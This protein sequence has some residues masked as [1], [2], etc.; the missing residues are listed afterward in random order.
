MRRRLL[1]GA[2]VFL[3]LI[4]LFLPGTLHAMGQQEDPIRRAEVLIEENR[5]NEAIRLLERTIR[6]EPER[7]HEAEDL[8][9]EIRRRRGSY[10]ELFQQLIAH[11]L[12][13]PEELETTLDIIDRMEAL[14][15]EPNQRT[16][17]QVA[18]AR[19]IAQI[20]YDRARAERAMNEALLALQEDR[21][22][23]AISIYL[24]LQEF[25]RE[26]FEARGYSDIFRTT[27]FS[28]VEQV[29]Q[30]TDSFLAISEAVSERS[31]ALI[32]NLEE[33][34]D[35]EDP[36]PFAVEELLEQLT[37]V[38]EVR[39]LLEEGAETIETQRQRVRLEF[40]DN[41]VEWY[42]VLQDQIVGGRSEHRGEEGLLPAIRRFAEYQIERSLEVATREADARREA[43]LRAFE[44][45]DY[46]AAEDLFPDM[47]PYYR[48]VER[49]VAAEQETYV[50][51]ITP[52]MA[53]NRF[54]EDALDRFLTAS[55]RAR[56]GEYSADLSGRIQ[57]LGF[58][59]EVLPQELVALEELKERTGENVTAVQELLTEWE[60]ESSGVL[61]EL[62]RDALPPRSRAV[63]EEVE[64]RIRRVLQTGPQRLEATIAARII[65]LTRGEVAPTEESVSRE[66][67]EV[68]SLVEGTEEQLARVEEG[69]D[70]QIS[71][72][73]DRAL[74]RYENLEVQ[75]TDARS[76]LS[77]LLGRFSEEPTYVREDRRVEGELEATEELLTEVQELEETVATRIAEM[78]SQIA[79]AE[80]LR[81]QGD[82]LVTETRAA[83]SALQVNTAR[84]LWEQARE[85][86]YDSLSIQEDEAFRE[87]VDELVLALGNEI[88]EAQNRLIVEEVR[89][90]IDEADELYDEDQFGESRELLVRAR[91]LWSEVYVDPNPEIERLLRLA[92]AALSIEE[93]REITE[94]DPLFPVLGNYLNLA[95]Q[96]YREG[97]ELFTSGREQQGERL[98]ERAIENLR[99]VREVRPLNWNARI[100]E[101][102]ILQITEQE[103]FP[104]VFE[105]R[106]EDAVDRID[107]GELLAV[108]GELEA[109]AEINPDYPGIQER[110]RE[111]EIELNLREDPVDQA[112]EAES[113]QLYSRAQ[114]LAEA[115][116]RDQTVVAV[117]LLEEAVDLNPN[118]Q[119]AKFLMDSLRIR[120]GGQA[121]VALSSADEQ[122]Y[123]LAETLFSQGQVARAFSIVERLLADSD[124]QGYPPLIELRRRIALRLGI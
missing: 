82:E 27:V 120:L 67:P 87:S 51:D 76:Q 103:N 13:N 14:D 96:D 5:L 107:D 115:G 47:S 85:A 116:S 49:L 104:E 11:L 113:N 88:Q 75:I 71:R 90:L 59:T 80:E 55:F 98:L 29:Y 22:E 54:E 33:P 89:E 124:N 101:L 72:F 7:I 97:R 52:S 114:Q 28:A 68:A 6:E 83:L 57:E 8:L 63:T 21:Y 53:E 66:L 46:A 92:N 38:S 122:Q 43:A 74:D 117:N 9:R 84:D 32:D 93:G 37:E 44:A 100:L 121:T 40:P 3:T 70:V 50:A 25:Q 42:L 91:E 123:R 58:D 112:R 111:L 19:V 24:T 12:E 16:R 35:P 23:E 73:P 79:E 18:Q 109:L 26:E 62:E 110:I 2:A 99:N 4:L 39:D 20:A 61:A 95:Q 45:E 17:Q 34:E 30:G 10:N 81:D 102:R 15:P 56:S 48:V 94:T 31:S 65:Q 86:Y 36:G 1:S 69:E 118:N 119:E 60:G 77:G 105:A 108:Y 41:P 64:E 78:E 106:Y